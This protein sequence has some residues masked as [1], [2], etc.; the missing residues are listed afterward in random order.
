MHR[1]SRFLVGLAAAA[2]TFASLWFTLGPEHFN[3]GHRSC[4]RMMEHCYMMNEEH[5]RDCC[6]Q[7]EEGV[8]KV[9]VIEKVIKTDTI[10]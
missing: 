1:R 9:I 2:I 6:E 5:H 3:R 8:K 4:H 7:P 10:K